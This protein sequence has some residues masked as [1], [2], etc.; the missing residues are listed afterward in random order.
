M[1][2][3]YKTLGC[4]H[5]LL[6]ASSPFDWPSVPALTPEGFARWQ[7]IQ[8]ML[9][10]GENVPFLQEA[11]RKYD[12]PR[13]DGGHFPK[14]LPK[15]CFP[16]KP[17]PEME[18]WYQEVTH[19]LG[20]EHEYYFPRFKN[21]PYMSPNPNN[22]YDRNS[23]YFPPPNV[24][25]NLLEARRPS[26]PSRNGSIDYDPASRRSSVPD[27]PSPHADAITWSADTYKSRGDYKK[28]TA[29]SHS[30]QRPTS[31][32]S[33]PRPSADSR[34]SAYPGHGLSNPPTPSHSVPD[35][36]YKANGP[37][38]PIARP[39]THPHQLRNRRPRTPSTPGSSSG[40]EAS[41]EDSATGRRYDRRRPRGDSKHKSFIPS[42][43][44]PNINLFG[45]RSRARRHSHDAGYVSPEKPPPLP[46]RPVRVEPPFR[47][48]SVVFDSPVRMNM[49]GPTAGPYSPVNPGRPP[50]SATVPNTNPGVRFR[51]RIFENVRDRD[52]DDAT[53]SAPD[54]FPS[55]PYN[56]PPRSSV[57]Q[58]SNIPAQVPPPPPPPQNSHLLTYDG[59]NAGAPLTRHSSASGSGSGGRDDRTPRHQGTGRPLRVA[60][61]T[62]VGGRRY[63]P[64]NS[65]GGEQNSAAPAPL[66]V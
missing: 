10:P 51:D 43:L 57:S 18:R 47:A 7:T 44:V 64:G 40:S 5:S 42:G 56:M 14:N 31:S 38:Q 24:R 13:P 60:T 26:K 20:H 39:Y 8:L 61:V 62:G 63:P 35:P 54:N 17:D 41:S 58:Q 6:P 46:P 55:F 9:V 23:G 25:P 59:Y 30:A 28:R 22:A 52:R 11:V 50:P 16:E 34:G 33:R 36:Y 21:S 12:V 49:S 4:F 15:D 45:S 65:N 2:F 37:S 29:R 19:Q 53:N 48:D 3:I 27:L 32:S 1:S 66:P